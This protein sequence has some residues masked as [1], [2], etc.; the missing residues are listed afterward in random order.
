MYPKRKCSYKH[1]TSSKSIR[2]KK[3][4]PYLPKVKTDA[5]TGTNSNEE[6]H[7]AFSDVCLAT[8]SQKTQTLP[9]KLRPVIKAKNFELGLDH[10]NSEENI[11]VNS[12]KLSDLVSI[13]QHDC[14]DPSAE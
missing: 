5:G 8:Q 14:T 7:D 4:H 9:S 3:G 12:N 2:F 11:V 1:T 13:F 6:V 10:T